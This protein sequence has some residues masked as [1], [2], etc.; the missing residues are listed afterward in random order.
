[1][2][3]AVSRVFAMIAMI[4]VLTVVT[5]LPRSAVA[6]VT[7]PVT[8]IG[9]IP[10]TDPDALLGLKRFPYC[11]SI[12]D[13]AGRWSVARCK[14]PCFQGCGSY[15]DRIA[16]NDSAHN[17]SCLATQNCG[18]ICPPQV[19]FIPGFLNPIDRKPTFDRNC[20][21]GTGGR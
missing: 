10:V 5:V 7:C 13:T 3:P 4:V 9:G 17:A 14:L 12:K 2:H 6:S 20:G 1:M 11:C 19:N 8:T 21:C 18:Y 15:V 16:C